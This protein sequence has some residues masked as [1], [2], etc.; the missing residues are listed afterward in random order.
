LV[1]ITKCREG[2]TT[3]LNISNQ[4]YETKSRCKRINLGIWVASRNQ[5]SCCIVKALQLEVV[6]H[7]KDEGA[8][9][10]RAQLWSPPQL[11]DE[12]YMEKPDNHVSSNY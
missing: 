10:T 4:K 7:L 5:V 9:T 11:K 3:A 6:L 1:S 8:R 2:Y 12:L